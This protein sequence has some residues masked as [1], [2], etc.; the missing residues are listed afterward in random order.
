MTALLALFLQDDSPITAP[1]TGGTLSGIWEMVR[2]SGPIAFCV[3]I[4]LLLASVFS[5]SIILSKWTGFGRAQSQS[6]RFLRAFRKSGRLSEIATVADQFRPSPLVNI[7]TEIVD[8]YQRQSGGRG[9]PRN[10][11]GLERAAQTAASEALT[12]MEKNMTW[13]STIASTSTFLGLFG[14]VM[15]II[16][17]FH[18]LGASGA[19]TLRAVA[20]G[21]SEAL[22]T[23]AAGILVAVPAYVGYNLFTG[24]LREFAARMDDFARELLNAIENAAM[25]PVPPEMSPQ[26]LR[27]DLRN[28]TDLDPRLR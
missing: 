28:D 24:R 12:A 10:P 13:L 18:G 3:L 25:L 27:R 26:P 6:T 17:A 5:W 22:I 11:L 9:M 15:G 1:V 21:V 19:A 14:T 4:I 7:F 23:T 8:E 20:P 2:N 16:D